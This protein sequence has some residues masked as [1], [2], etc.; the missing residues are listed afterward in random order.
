MTKGVKI[1]REQTEKQAKVKNP[2]ARLKKPALLGIKIRADF[3]KLSK[4]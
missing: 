3:F 2:V 1:E 4:I